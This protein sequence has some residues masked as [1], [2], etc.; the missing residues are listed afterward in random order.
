MLKSASDAVSEARIKQC[1]SS[2]FG[3]LSKL[4]MLLVPFS[5][6]TL[7][8]MVVCLH[9]AYSS[10]SAL[11]RSEHLAAHSHSPCKSITHSTDASALLLLT[12]LQI[13]AGIVKGLVEACGK[14]CPGVR[15]SGS[16]SSS[17][18]GMESVAEISGAV[19]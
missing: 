18:V 1:C 14:H 11:Q 7:R 4:R 12:L 3:P 8:G 9:Q 15:R 17:T 10:D 16:S 2:Y 5:W 13:N 6:C 19:T